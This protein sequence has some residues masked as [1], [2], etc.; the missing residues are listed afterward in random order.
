M[1]L[2]L[3][4][5]PRNGEG[6]FCRPDVCDLECGRQVT[7]MRGWTSLNAYCVFAQP[8][9]EIRDGRHPCLTRTFLGGDFIPN[10]TLI[11]GAASVDRSK[12]ESDCGASLLLLTGPNMGGKSTLM[13]QVALITILAQMVR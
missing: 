4:E 10:D 9:L 6:E 13:R 8:F 11:G 2:A 7:G 12:P 1:L 3:A 5:F